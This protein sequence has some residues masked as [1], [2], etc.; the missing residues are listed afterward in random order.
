MRAPILTFFN[1]K[2]GVGKTSLVYHLAWM[3]AE[4][5]KKVLVLDLDP[6]ANLTSAMLSEEAL[7]K[8]WEQDQDGTTVFKCVRPMTGFRDIVP[9]KLQNIASGLFLLPG[10]VALSGFEEVLSGE[11]TKALGVKDLYRPLKILSAFWQ[12]ARMG[13]EQIQAEVVLVDVGPNLGAINRSALTAT[14]FVAIPLAADLFSLQGLQNLGPTLREWRELWQRIKNNWA[15]S[16]EAKREPAF[17]LPQGT[18]Q[19]IGYLC[20]QPSIRMD[21]PVKA[22]DKWLLRMPK[23]YR[24]YVLDVADD[25]PEP[26]CDPECLATLRHYRSL[27][28]MGQEKRKPI[29]SL[30]PADG[31]VGSHAQA[32]AAARADFMAL[33]RKIADRIG[34]SLDDTDL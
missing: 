18:M 26:A 2:G 12:L 30:T 1:N 24:K 33:A 19:P 4:Y 5:R 14:D 15:T 29:F 31:A 22:Y 34:L 3:F 27:I 25:G 16:A 11:S 13:A 9:P 6:Q 20:Q 23:M 8:I 7:E 21:R 10:D 32:V 17:T 28:P